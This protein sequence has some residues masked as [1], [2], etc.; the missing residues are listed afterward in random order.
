[1]NVINKNR[2]VKLTILFFIIT[3]IIYG[4]ILLNTSFPFR[5]SKNI[6][7]GLPLP[8]DSLSRI[9]DI[10]TLPLFFYTGFKSV[11]YSKWLKKIGAFDLEDK[12]ILNWAWLSLIS[13]CIL[14]TDFSNVKWFL[15]VFFSLHCLITAAIYTLCIL[16]YGSYNIKTAVIF[17]FGAIA[18]FGF[19]T[20]LFYG[21]IFGIIILLSAIASCLIAILLPII[22]M[23]IVKGIKFLIS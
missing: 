7:W 3:L 2:P 5:E 4:I 20:T 13:P 6:L 18:F 16:N 22:I 11:L 10:L 21:S 12:L 1:M 8:L 15:L 17:G 19:L 9:F 14:F 23:S